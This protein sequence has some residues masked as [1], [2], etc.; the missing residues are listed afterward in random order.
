[1][2]NASQ[3]QQNPAGGPGF[4]EKHVTGN[5]LSFLH[6][7]ASSVKVDEKANSSEAQRQRIL[8]TLHN[9]SLTTL[10]ARRELDV[11]HPA[12]RIMELRKQGYDIQTVRVPDLTSEGFAHYVARYILRQSRQEVAE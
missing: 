4:A 7:E 3:K 12:A 8:E 10:E 9:R 1:M 5:D 11:L 2:A 6:H